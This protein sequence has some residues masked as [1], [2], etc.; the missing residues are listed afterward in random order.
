MF[1]LNFGAGTFNYYCSVHPTVM[2]GTFQVLPLHDAGVSKITV[3]R[4]FAYSGV[5]S[6][7]IQLNVTATNSGAV[8]DTFYVA[9]KANSTLIGN[10]TVTLPAGGTAI[11][12]FNWNTQ[13]L[14]RGIY[15]LTAQATLSG[16]GNPSNNLVTDGTFTV[17][18]KGDVNGDCKVDIVDLATVGST[19]GKVL[20]TAGYNPNADLNNDG[21]INIVDLVVVGGSFGQTCP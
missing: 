10:Q 5:T 6:N 13:P 15:T 14:A 11:V 4:N 9:A 3:S 7:P 20:G 2:F 1:T 8:T 18:L 12:T 21:V 16:D 19:F 17:K